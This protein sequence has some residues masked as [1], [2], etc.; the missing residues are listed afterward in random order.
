MIGETGRESGSPGGGH[1]SRRLEQRLEVLV[2]LSLV[3]PSMIL[4]WFVI[5]P[6]RLNFVL[7][8]W[9]VILRDLSLVGLVVFFAWRN[10]EPLEGIGWA[11]RNRWRDMRLGIVLFLPFFAAVNALEA[12]LRAA[13]LSAPSAASLA[14]LTPRGRAEVLL[15]LFLVVIVAATEETIFR[16]YL[17][18]RFTPITGSP[19]AAILLSS[20]VFSLGHGYEGTAGVATVAFM[21]VMLGLVYVWRGSIV[22]PAVMHFLQDFLGIV[23]APLAGVR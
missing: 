19:L 18:L 22:A 23:L 6:G 2:F 5:R 4:S 20:A 14:F 12:G 1:R 17:I 15:G 13:G 7:V 16:G 10:Q 3:V 21:G 8:A 9:S 11:F